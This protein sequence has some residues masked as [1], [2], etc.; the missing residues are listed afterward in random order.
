[1]RNENDAVSILVGNKVATTSVKP[2]PDLA[3]RAIRSGSGLAR[4][5][6]I[7]IVKRA[8]VAFGD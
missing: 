8:L 7:D 2:T 4:C 6:T 5:L 1:M 3:P